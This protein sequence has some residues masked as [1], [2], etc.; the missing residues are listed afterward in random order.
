MEQSKIS[1]KTIKQN[2]TLSDFE[3]K[4]EN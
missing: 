3:K 4:E 1:Y 2:S